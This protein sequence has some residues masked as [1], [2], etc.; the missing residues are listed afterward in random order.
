MTR[1]KTAVRDR[2]VNFFGKIR[3]YTRKLTTESIS[4]VYWNRNFLVVNFKDGI[5]FK[6]LL[7]FLNNLVQ[8]SPCSFG[9]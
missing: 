8:N 1:E 4:N 7:F 6:R 9:I 5:D 3:S 2:R